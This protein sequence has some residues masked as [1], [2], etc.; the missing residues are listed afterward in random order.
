MQPV[1]QTQSRMYCVLFA[2]SLI[3]TIPYTKAEFYFNFIDFKRDFLSTF[4]VFFYPEMRCFSTINSVLKV[5]SSRNHKSSINI[6]TYW[7]VETWYQIRDNILF[8]LNATKT[9]MHGLVSC[10]LAMRYETF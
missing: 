1:N 4:N 3:K 6:N 8:I 7:S 10:L 9:L 5:N 2:L